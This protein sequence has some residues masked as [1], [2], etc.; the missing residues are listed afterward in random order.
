MN[1]YSALFLISLCLLVRGQQREREDLAKYLDCTN[2]PRYGGFFTCDSDTCE[3]LLLNGYWVGN[4]TPGGELLVVSCP[5]GYCT[6]NETGRHI[7]IPQNLSNLELN[8]F[9]CNASHR[10]GIVCGECQPG[11]GPAI[12]SDPSICVSCDSQ[13]SKV[14]WIY[15]ILAVYVPLL[16][17]FLLIIIFNI[18]L[19]TGPVN[20]FI[21]FAQV[22][23]TTVDISQQGTAPLNLL[24]GSGTRDFEQAYLIPYGFFNLDILGNILPPFCLQQTLHSLDI[25][26]LR[27]IEALFPV[28][29][30]IGV[31][32]LVRCQRYFKVK[33][34]LPSRL[35]K[36]RV[37]G[38]LVQVFA[39]F[40][41]L[42]YNRLCQITA[43]L[44]TPSLGFDQTLQYVESRVFFEGAYKTDDSYYIARYKIPAYFMTA[45]LILVPI[46]LLHYPM[47]W[48]ERGLVSKIGW[49]RRVYPSANIAILLDTFQGCFKDN[50]R[51][52]AGIYLILRLM[53]F[54]AFFQP[55][56]L[57]LLIQQI[58][59]VVYVFLLAYFK[60]YRE[61]HY[62]YLD[63]AMFTN[64]A[65][66]NGLCWFTVTVNQTGP[67]QV[68]LVTCI[69]F[70]SIL[71]FLPLVYLVAY[72]LW[73]STKS[74]HD[75]IK[76]WCLSFRKPVYDP[77]VHITGVGEEYPSTTTDA[78]TDDDFDALT[79][80]QEE[81]QYGTVQLRQVSS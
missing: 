66:I 27:Y 1:P 20:S 62:N 53:L 64:L 14:N 58:F 72:I 68:A 4:T 36:Y 57:Q 39:A 76:E 49:L 75:R 65:L 13:S 78:I 15:Y 23:S 44:L 40:I 21:L 69:L 77:H 3:W 45:L 60:P 67:N 34:T 10:K 32:A 51:Y 22:I 31:V 11:Y 50:R 47:K 42:S 79:R 8:D 54:F 29:I 71:V 38:H 63:T 43:Y 46:T 81:P 33:A 35:Q 6:I 55:W 56:Q 16:V 48:L 80:R 5:L 59:F 30:I 9:F 28:V 7:W 61:E 25:I 18:R 41:L 19:T 24:Y 26:A 74:Y 12:N 73:Y 37:G 70:E 17:I 52:F 2:C